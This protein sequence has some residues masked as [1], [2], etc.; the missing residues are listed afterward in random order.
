MPP[1]RFGHC[2]RPSSLASAEPLINSPSA[3]CPPG[4]TEPGPSPGEALQVGARGGGPPVCRG[5]VD[6]P[7]ADRAALTWASVSPL[8]GGGAGA[9]AGARGR[10]CR[11]RS[12]AGGP[13]PRETV[14]RSEVAAAEERQGPTTPTR[15]GMRK[16]P[17]PG[18]GAQTVLISWPQFN[19]AQPPRRRAHPRGPGPPHPPRAHSA[20]PALGPRPR[21]ALRPLRA[22]L[23]PCPSPRPPALR[24]EQGSCSGGLVR[25]P[26]PCLA[27]GRAWGCP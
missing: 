23:G 17:R 3:L 1:G 13:V 8:A 20:H 5:Q 25:V 22:F 7:R 27:A 18:P 19:R 4:T 16:E 6:R 21:P 9:G 26:W 15:P 11:R 2:P 24:P 14:S 10:G 12:L